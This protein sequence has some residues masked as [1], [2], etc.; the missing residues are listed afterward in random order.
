M[1]WTPCAYNKKYSIW[2]EVGN[3]LLIFLFFSCET[4]T[5][6]FFEKSEACI[7]LTENKKI[8][9]VFSKGICYRAI[10]EQVD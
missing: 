9:Y 1:V 2:P 10:A 3:D 7:R 4:C 5:F 6:K 8:L